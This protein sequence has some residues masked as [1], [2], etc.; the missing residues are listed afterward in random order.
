M[1]VITRDQAELRA[2]RAG[3]EE[4][5][6]ERVP[7]SVGDFGIGKYPP[8][9]HPEVREVFG[10]LYEEARSE[11]VRQGMHERWMANYVISRAKSTVATRLRDIVRGGHNA[12]L[13]LGLIGAN[14]ER[15]VANITARNPVASVQAT[16]GDEAVSSTLSAMVDQWHN[17]EQQH[18]TLE[19]AVKIQETYGTVV[20]KGVL[21]PE[22]GKL[23]P[24]PLDVTAFLPAPGK[25][26]DIQKLPYCC[27]HY[28]QD[29]S[30]IVA[31]YPDLNGRVTEISG[32]DD[33]FLVERE[34]RVIESNLQGGGPSTLPGSSGGSPNHYTDKSNTLAM[35]GKKG[36]VVEIWCKDP[37]MKK[38]TKKVVAGIDP[39]TGIEQ[40]V[41]AES[42]D[43]V[44]PGG[45]RLVV[46][47]Q[48]VDNDS[49]RGSGEYIV[50]YDGPN[51]NI[52]WHIPTEYLKA[53]Y[54]YKRY[55]F[56][57]SRSYLDTEMFWGFSQAE[58]TGDIAQAID[59]LWRIIVKY[60]KLS[61]LPPVIIPKDTGIDKSQF[62]YIERLVLQPNSAT[63]A[64][65]IRFLEMPTPPAWLFQALDVLTRFFDRTSQIED[66]DRGDA[67]AGIVA[68]SAIQM[69]Q[70]RAAAL[71][72][73]KIRAVDSLVRNRGRMF[74][75]MV[76]NFHA[77]PEMVNVS[78]SAVEVAGIQFAKERFSY[79]VES[80]S[81]VIKTEAEER[82]MAMDLFMAAAIDQRAL[83]EA[84]KFRG[85][86]EVIERMNQEGP[87]EQAMQVLVQA[88]LD[89][90][91][92]E[93]IYQFAMQ[94]Q[95]GPGDDPVARGGNSNAQNGQPMAGGGG[96]GGQGMRGKTPQR[97]NGGAPAK[98]G[99][100]M[101]QQNG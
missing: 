6:D 91:L 68:A 84:V 50:A 34:D 32:F 4:E 93:Q 97:Q 16:S 94:N 82:Q 19:L 100:P 71:V 14:I 60:L 55:P 52:N 37:Q 45:V 89:P 59:E 44:F 51:P 5:Q 67:P 29:I 90:A 57:V 12:S 31:R 75:S 53:C 2:M 87:L 1:E 86:R 15:T 40:Y 8:P 25:I 61:L 49:M 28:A 24:C 18:Q 41:D 62:A 66:V 46:L 13:S 10:R 7:R 35:Y 80:G 77:E 42:M 69:L 48:G 96:G 83:L 85:W 33:L 47:V 39:E 88:G 9:G 101:T 98:A 78:G 36:L 64:S 23:T 20:E 54:L 26:H 74:I 27:H 38:A 11:V 58:T 56:S 81:T 73:A 21:D 70:E 63:T 22:T 17:E 99:V 95:G 72:R 76:Q 3:R 30:Q 65:G 92:V 79:I 43:E